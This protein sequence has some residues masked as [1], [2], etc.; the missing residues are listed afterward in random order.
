[1]HLMLIADGR[2]PITRAWLRMLRPLG[3]RLTLV[4][5]YPCSAPA[6][7]EHFEVLPV[8]FGA[9][10]GVSPTGQGRAAFRKHLRQPLQR[11]RYWLGPLTL[12]VYAPRLRQLVHRL[13]PEVIHA[14][15]IPYE[16]MLATYAPPEA[17]LVLSIWGNDLTL[18]ARGSPWMARLT[19]RALR[20]AA[21]LMTDC[22]RDRDLAYWW[23]F[24][25][26]KP[27]LVVPGNGGL[28]LERLPTLRT[29]LGEPWATRLEG[30]EARWVLNPRG[31]RQYVLSDVFF[32]VIPLVRERL[33]E[34]RFLCPGMAGQPQAETWVRRLRLDETVV[35]LPTL[36]Q[37]QLWD[38]FAR[39]PV[40]I[41]LATH[42]GTPNTLLEAM[43][44]GCFPVLGDLQSLREWVTP[45]VNG[46]LVDWRRPQ[47]IAE[48]LVLA[49]E[50][51]DLRQHAAEINR[52]LIRERAEVNQVRRQMQEFFPQFCDSG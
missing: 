49:L 34:V 43:A 26:G 7:V 28:D 24:D 33:P 31:I 13:Q 16:G 3:W 9:A 25:S 21:A 41:S 52:A 8:A 15:R 39:A 20:R 6:E 47:S 29:R 23:G 50:M 40:M 14:L 48:A 46:L 42:D 35:L 36:P 45:G 27:S 10:G 12:G 2:S 1:M 30:D 51:P 19:R 18:H 38:L 32:Q 11:L 22:R 37:G 44:W 4:S 17:P 5:T